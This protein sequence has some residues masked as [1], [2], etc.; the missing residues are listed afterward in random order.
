[1]AEHPI[2]NLM[3]TT[4]TSL[5]NMIDVNT[6]VGDIVTTPDGTV[7]IPVSKVSFGFAAGGS[8]FSA[9]H[10]EQKL[11]FGGGSGAGVNIAPMAFLVV[12]ENNVRLLTLDGTTPIDKLIELIPDALNKAS[13]FIEKSIEKPKNKK[14]NDEVKKHKIITIEKERDSDDNI[15]RRKESIVDI[16]VDYEDENE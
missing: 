15:K 12:K 10:D 2:E 6:I 1:M 8:E 11:P 9:H 13:S 4:M 16:D 5:E 3:M 14:E 7:I